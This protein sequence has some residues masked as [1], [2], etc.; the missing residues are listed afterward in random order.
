MLRR[1]R[2][3]QR[4]WH[5]VALFLLCSMVSLLFARSDQNKT[6]WKAILFFSRTA[7][8]LSF[9]HLSCR[10]SDWFWPIHN[11]QSQNKV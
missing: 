2:S 3:R 7:F 4:E 6:G 10:N 5:V 11:P 8:S 1:F 9:D